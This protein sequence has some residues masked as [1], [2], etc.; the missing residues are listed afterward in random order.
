MGEVFGE[1]RAKCWDADGLRV[2]RFG[3][4]FLRGFGDMMGRLKRKVFRGSCK[5][6]LKPFPRK[7]SGR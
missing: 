2:L 5:T 6:A 7:G 1:V 4:C 3:D